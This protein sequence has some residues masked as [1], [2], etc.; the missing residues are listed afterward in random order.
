MFTSGTLNLYRFR[1]HPAQQLCADEAETEAADG[2]PVSQFQGKMSVAYRCDACAFAHSAS[3]SP[4][5]HRPSGVDP[6][7]QSPGYYPQQEIKYCAKAG[8]GHKSYARITINFV[9]YHWFLVKLKANS[10]C[11]RSL[12][13]ADCLDSILNS[14]PSFKT[15]SISVKRDC[16]HLIKTRML[17][18]GRSP[19]WTYQTVSGQVVSA[20]ESR[21]RF[22]Q[23][24]TNLSKDSNCR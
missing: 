22:N 21:R 16:Y 17:I 11:K 13:K 2:P 7:K 15:Q 5:Q 14:L 20:K 12:H 1:M 24:C 23:V 18:G 8:R 4:N 10:L 9:Q 3:L 19:W 6:K